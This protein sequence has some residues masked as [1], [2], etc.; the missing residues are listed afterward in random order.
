MR[1]TYQ[2]TQTFGFM[3]RGSKLHLLSKQDDVW[4]SECVND[5]GDSIGKPCLPFYE[6][7]FD[8]NMELDDQRLAVYELLR[9]Q[10]GV[11]ESDVCL[12]CYRGRL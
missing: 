10:S 6:V 7:E 4:M 3:G 8:G 11:R 5:G 12:L 1:I 2:M 9:Q